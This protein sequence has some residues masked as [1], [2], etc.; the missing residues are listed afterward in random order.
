LNAWLSIFAVVCI[1]CCF[2][3]T[4]SNNHAHWLAKPLSIALHTQRCQTVIAQL[5]KPIKRIFIF[6]LN[7]YSEY[8]FPAMLPL[9]HVSNSYRQS[10]HDACKEQPSKRKHLCCARNKRMFPCEAG[11]ALSISAVRFLSLHRDSVSM[12]EPD[13]DVIVAGG[14]MAGLITAASI[15]VFSKQ[16]FRILVVDRNLESEPGKKTGSGWICGD[17]VSKNSVDYLSQNTGITYG[18][19]E[20]EHNV[21][22]I[23]VYSPDHRT[24]VLFEG[25]GYILNRKLLPRRQ[26]EDAKKRGVEFQHGV[27]LERLISNDGWVSGVVGRMKSGEVFKKTARMVVDATGSVSLLRMNLPVK[28]KIQR[29]IDKDDLESTGRYIYEFERGGDDPSYFDPKYAIIHLDQYL[30]P[31]GYAWTFPKG[32]NKVNVGLGYQ[33]RALDQRNKTFGKSQGLQELIDE[34]VAS[35]PV[36]KNPRLSTSEADRGNEK[37]NWQVPVRRPNDC[38]VANGY[39]LVGDAA[40]MPRPIDAGGIGPSIYGSVILGRCVAEALESN[41]VSENGLWKYNVEYM[42]HYGFRMA[43]FEVLRRYLQTLPNSDIDFGMRYFLSEEDIALIT[44]REHP[45]FR[46]VD[47]LNPSFIRRVLEKPTLAR[48]LKYTSDKSER[49]IAHNQEYPEKPELFESWQKKLLAE[50][51]ET[52]SKFGLVKQ[53]E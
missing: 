44:R 50:L 25:K 40:W 48:G 37:G 46:N 2:A 15:A 52:Y 38:M 11:V 18:K 12:P 33:K 51:Q 26:V 24:K 21:E 30:A 20:L 14:G 5:P 9:T 43:S 28:S 6:G 3:S 35:N 53:F 42:R 47:L 39:A 31:G 7:F 32:E 22:G 49:L 4:T 45:R 10:L 16:N 41:D 17:A 13:Y 27:F 1:R 8:P 19:P 36:I 34:Y 29:E 23:Y